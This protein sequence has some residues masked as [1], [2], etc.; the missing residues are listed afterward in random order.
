[1]HLEEVACGTECLGSLCHSW[2]KL[3]VAHGLAIACAWS[4]YAVGAVHDDIG[5]N[6]LHIRNVAEIYHEIVVA[7]AVA[8]LGEPYFAGSA[9]QSLLN[10]ILHI[11]S[12]EELSLLDVDNLAGLGSRYEQVGLA[13]EEGWYLENIAYLAR[14]FSLIALVDIGGDAKSVFRLDVAE[15]L[16][17]FLQTR[18]TERVDAGSVGLIEGCL[19]YDVGS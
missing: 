11:S 14:S 4:L 10:R 13:A 18:T 19:E 3:A 2:Y 12:A 16:Q 5:Y 17:T 9:I 1:M 7:E 6:L 8:T 15:H